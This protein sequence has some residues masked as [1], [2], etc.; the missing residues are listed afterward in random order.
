MSSTLGRDGAWYILSIISHRTISR[1]LVID[2]QAVC[3][4]YFLLHPRDSLFE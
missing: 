1:G 4:I 3:A 2:T